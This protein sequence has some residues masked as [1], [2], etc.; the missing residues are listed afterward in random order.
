MRTLSS[1]RAG[2]DQGL[3]SNGVRWRATR[4]GSYW[5][6]PFWLRF[7]APGRQRR[8][9]AGLLLSARGEGG[10]DFWS[11]AASVVG[12]RLSAVWLLCGNT[13]IT[14]CEFFLQRV[15]RTVP[16][17]K[18]SGGED[19][20]S[21]P[22][23][24]NQCDEWAPAALWVAQAPTRGRIPQ[25]STATCSGPGPVKDV[26][27]VCLRGPEKNGS[28]SFPTADKLRRGLYYFQP[29]F[30]GHFTSWPQD[31]LQFAEKSVF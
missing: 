25:R 9:S 17:D 1:L 15:V 7:N 10:P 12:Q 13:I 14:S 18:T 16:L 30:L 23:S 22:P 31:D 21:R 26:A 29:G 11:S 19:A 27:L 24:D 28:V 2:R 4:S 8:G 3:G 5:N 20:E 6:F